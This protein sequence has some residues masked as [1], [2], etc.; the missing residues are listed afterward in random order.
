MEWC[1]DTSKNTAFAIQ[2][3]TK[4]KAQL[5]A[6]IQE[7]TSDMDA[8]ST[9]IDSLA[10]EIATGESELKDATLIR[11]KETADFAASEKELVASI[12]ALSRAVAIL[13][14]EMAKNPAAFAQVDPKDLG[15]ALQ[16]F[17][18][19]LDAAA[20]SGSDQKQLA[21]LVQ[22]QQTED[23]DDEL[24]SPAAAAYKTHSGNILDVLEDLKEKAEGQL[25]DL[26]KAEVNTQHNFDMLKQSLEDQM[27]ADTKDMND[28]K[29]GKAA[30]E[31]G[32]TASQSDLDM[33][34]KELDNSKKQ[35]ATAQSSCLK[36]AA[37]Y[38]A[39]VAARNEE[40]KVIAEAQK[41]LAETTSGAEGQTYS[42]MQY[43]SS[44]SVEPR[45]CLRQGERL[46]PGDDF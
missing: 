25:S 34:N 42:L 21:A 35:L 1:D 7:L 38:E 4:S 43:G 11:G 15:G 46:D 30:A 20:L 33:T 10:S 27:A 8:A 26:R 5:E 31:G 6:K 12:D 37:D 14:K 22:S 39:T 9:K 13:Q 23:A 24:G 18:A 2:T 36:V 40:L 3:A 44:R 17:S 41:I 32:K 29:A 19:V 16:A 28:E 45:R